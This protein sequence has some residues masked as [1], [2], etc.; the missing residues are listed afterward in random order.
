VKEFNSY[1]LNIQSDFLIKVFRENEEEIDLIIPLD[2]RT[3]NLYINAMPK[4]IPSR[5]Q[6]NDVN[7]ILI[8]LC[9]DLN[10]NIGTI[11]F[12]NDNGIH[13]TMSNFEIDYKGHIFQILFKEYYVDFLI[14]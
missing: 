3:T 8:R 12:L 6:F 9:K 2:K 4:F 11:H 1:N 14:N 7:S 10:N 13:S 5:I